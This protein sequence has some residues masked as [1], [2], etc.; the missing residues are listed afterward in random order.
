MI[1]KYLALIR[2][3]WS[4]SLEYRAE[5]ILWM[6]SNLL[7]IIMLLVW[8][9]IS[10]NGPVGGFNS[11]DFVAYYMVGLVVRHLTGVWASWE[12]SN[13]IREGNLSAQLLRPIHPV[14]RHVTAN[15]SEHFMRLTMLFPLIVIVM[16][17]TPDAH[18]Y[19]TPVSVA[20]F[21]LSLA[22]AWLISFLSDYAIGILAFWVS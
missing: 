20:A 9:S 3:A 2:M 16:L 11:G 21:I 1:R 8:L 7:S 15:W 14:H 22:G 10:R 19:V 5:Q 12:L 13:D 18:L 4:L 6:L 17:A